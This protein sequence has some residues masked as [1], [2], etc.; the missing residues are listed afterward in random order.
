[1]RYKYFNLALVIAP[2]L[3]FCFLWVYFREE[4]EAHAVRCD[5]LNYRDAYA[6]LLGEPRKEKK[7]EWY[8]T[9]ILPIFERHPNVMGTSDPDTLGKH[10]PLLI[11]LPSARNAYIGVLYGD[12]G[13]N[14]TDNPVVAVRLGSKRFFEWQDTLLTNPVIRASF[15]LMPK[16]HLKRSIMQM[17]TSAE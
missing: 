17:I 2:V 7:L 11:I 5:L 12:Y 13:N 8:R 9:R 6:K 15:T 3:I 14:E 1:M 10:V 16:E 4:A